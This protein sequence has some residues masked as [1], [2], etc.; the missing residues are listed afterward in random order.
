MKIQTNVRVPV[1]SSRMC[2]VCVRAGACVFLWVRAILYGVYTSNLW[3]SQVFESALSW[4]CDF[5][6]WI[7][8]GITLLV[9]F[10]A[11]GSRIS[12]PKIAMPRGCMF[13]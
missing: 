13:C 1:N 8:R 4:K 2:S 5:S 6:T 7:E 3:N 9:S 11:L 12:G 10:S